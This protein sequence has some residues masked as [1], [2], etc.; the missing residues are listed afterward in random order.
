M[1]TE[2][3]A[4]SLNVLKNRTTYSYRIG[5][6]YADNTRNVTAK[7]YEVD[8]YEG[9]LEFYAVVL[10]VETVKDYIGTTRMNEEVVQARC[11]IPKI[12]A[13]YPLPRSNKDYQI[14]DLFPMFQG[15]TAEFEEAKPG[16]LV[17][18]KFADRNRTSQRVGNGKLIQLMD[19]NQAN[20][21]GIG[22]ELTI[23]IEK[24]STTKVNAPSGEDLWESCDDLVRSVRNP[25]K[26][27]SQ[28]AE[29]STI[30]DCRST[31]AL[32][33][34]ER[35]SYSEHKRFGVAEIKPSEVSCKTATILSKISGGSGGG[36]KN[37]IPLP[38]AHDGGLLAFMEAVAASESGA[39]AYN[40]RRQ[41]FW[42]KE[43]KVCAD[44]KPT[45]SQYWGKYQLGEKA[46]VDAF[47][48]VWHNFDKDKRQ[49]PLL[50]NVDLMS[51][52]DS[53]TLKIF[54]G[55]PNKD[56]CA[57]TN[58]WK[59][60]DPKGRWQTFRTYEMKGGSFKGKHF[61]EVMGVAWFAHGYNEV[62]KVKAFADA[63]TAGSITRGGTK[64]LVDLSS[65]VAVRHILGLA[66]VSK[67][68]ANP[69]DSANAD[70]FGTTAQCY[71]M[72]FYGYDLKNL[73]G[74][75]T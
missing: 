21:V 40:A 73:A 39:D 7:Q 26:I 74:L 59:P 33:G 30:N 22:F 36:C 48:V 61:Q 31:G 43:K 52:E 42:K 35:P 44:D 69:I 47:K 23:C 11:F 57:K 60:P 51:K 72:K 19:K 34:N 56:Q 62:N 14:I 55:G 4:R 68:L 53:K 37:G 28:W 63:I 41:M 9:Q 25:K 3:D 65:L 13:C 38:M 32:L 2:K 54:N 12:H 17:R 5:S 67:Y 71:A 27:N 15:S 66:G 46:R 18:V 20:A 10:S 64:H 24:P 6:S 8:V 70:Q 45:G 16:R 29:S 58:R 50:K 49:P 75:K 1:A